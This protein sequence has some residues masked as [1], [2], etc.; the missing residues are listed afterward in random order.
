MLQNVNATRME[1]LQLRRRVALAMRG[2]RLLSEKRDEISRQ[3]VLISKSLKM[4]RQQVEKEL[5]ETSRRFVIARSTMEPESVNAALEIPT[6]K[7]SLTIRFASIMNVKVPE[8]TKQSEGDILCYGFSTTSGELDA[9]LRALERAFDM[10]IELAGKEKQA[11]LL[12]SELQST[13]RRVNVLEHVVIPELQETI[14][15]IYNKLGEAE[16]DNISRLMIIA[17]MIRG[18]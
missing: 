15:Y 3:L 2:H 5:L 4:L 16:R 7:F 10:L 14:R 17:D 11:Q 18:E 1:M 12:A 9:A 13:R 8:L 6:K